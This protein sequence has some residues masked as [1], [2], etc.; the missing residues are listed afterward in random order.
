MCM[1][2]RGPRDAQTKGQ[3]YFATLYGDIA[4]S[5]STMPGRTFSVVSMSASVLYLPNENRIE[6]CAAVYG[7]FIAR[8][9]EDDSCVVE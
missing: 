2:A 5:F 6:P 4:A 8:N 9:V 7:T 1:Y 3:Y